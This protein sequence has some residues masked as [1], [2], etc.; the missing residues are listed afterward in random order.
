MYIPFTR[1]TFFKYIF[2]IS[3]LCQG[4]LALAQ[5][6]S[7]V[8]DDEHPRKIADPKDRIVLDCNYDT[9]LH[10]PDGINE[11]P[12]S[13]GLNAYLMWDYPIGYGPF[14]IAFGLGLS[15]H[16]VHTNGRITYSLDGKYTSFVP[17][18]TPFKTNKL[19]FNYIEVPLELRIR[20]RGEKSFKFTVGGKIGYAYNIHTKYEDSDGKIK[21]Y[22]IKNIEDF[23]YG[24]TGRIGYN[25]YT[26]QAFY[27]L[28]EI[29][30]MKRITV[31]IFFSSAISQIIN[32]QDIAKV[33]TSWKKG[34]FV[35]LSFNQ[36][37]LTN[38]AAGGENALSGTFIGN[39]FANY[40]KEK[41][42]W[43]NTLDVGYGMLKSG[44]AKVRKNE[45]KIELN[46]KYGHEAIEHFYYSALIN[47]KTQF[48]PGYAYP[49]D[50]GVISRF[51]APAY[52]SL[53]LGM[54]YKPT[55]YFSL[56][57]SP[58]TGRLVIVA[59]QKLADAGQFGVDPATYDVNGNKLTN[60]KQIRTEF[61]AYL[62][63]RFQKDIF[64]N[65]NLLSTLNLFN[66]YTDKISRSFPNPFG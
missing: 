20:T 24:L 2:F 55:D 38:W 54:D 11:K 47:A 3:L 48:A 39:F 15:A 43:D 35:S 23:R 65:V 36:V 28:S 58:A 18:T 40:K 22:K 29:F 42:I 27:S 6:K 61:G 63:A 41:A 45:D 37:S 12:L 19:S 32:A 62:R 31:L 52:L 4:K 30:K 5:S 46:S 44:D 10:L 49:N 60:G 21:V 50:S 34:G 64:K 1:F 57:L 53:A 14:S 56:F 59:D 17:I 33:D 26:L 8:V 7:Q 51:A 13:L 66:N 25:K 16:N 9:Y